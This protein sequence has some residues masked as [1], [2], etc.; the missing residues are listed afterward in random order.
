MTKLFELP[1]HPFLWT[2]DVIFEW[3]L[4]ETHIGGLVC[5]STSSMYLHILRSNQNLQKNP[6]YV[7]WELYLSVCTVYT[8]YMLLTKALIYGIIHLNHLRTLKARF[9]FW[10]LLWIKGLERH[11]N[12]HSL[13]HLLRYSLTH[14]STV[15][16]KP[17]NHSIFIKTVSSCFAELVETSL[18]QSMRYY[19]CRGCTNS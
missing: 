1:A 9:W 3:P 4:L 16:P 13:T 12:F 19:G 6:M 8:V 18:W 17:I 11:H 7:Q 14:Y 2:R 15:Q 10:R 5:I